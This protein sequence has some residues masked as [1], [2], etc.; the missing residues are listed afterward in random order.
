MY[1]Q[2]PTEHDQKLQTVLNYVLQAAMLY[3]D[4][5]E[6]SKVVSILGTDCG[7][8]K[9][10]SLPRQLAIQRIEELKNTTEL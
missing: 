7:W 10:S 8:F 9:N 5:C 4:N 1:G 3:V 2:T 6:F